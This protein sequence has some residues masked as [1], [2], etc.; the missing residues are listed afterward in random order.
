MEDKKT[1]IVE[2]PIFPLPNTVF[3]P[4][5]LLPL[6]IFEPRYRLMVED[7]KENHNLIAMVLLKEGWEKDYFGHPDVFEIA[8]VGEVQHKEILDDGKY[9]IMLYGTSRVKIL[10][11]IQ[12]KPYRKARVQYLKDSLFDHQEFNE[13]LEMATF[14]TLLRDYLAELGVQQTDELIEL[15][16]HSLES[17]VNHAASILDFTI[18]EKQELLE[19]GRLDDRYYKLKRL[20]NSKKMAI[21]VARSVKYIP[22]DPSLN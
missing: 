17:L 13:N 3:F 20:L 21:R 14:V 22:E 10:D 4:K 9:N 12:D 2:V 19:L 5:T 8:C 1:L 11:F 18:S 15:Q 7:A 6:H 16:S